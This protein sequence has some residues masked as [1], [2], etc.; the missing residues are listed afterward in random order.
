MANA[1]RKI[2]TQA[3]KIRKRHKSMS[4]KSAVKKA[5]AQYKKG[6]LKAR[7]KSVG[8]VKKTR[9]RR[10]VKRSTARKKT[11]RRK[12]T[13]AVRRVVVIA[14]ARPRRRRSYAKKRSAPRRRVGSTRKDKFLQTLLIGG[15][16]VALG[17]ALFRQNRTQTVYVPTGN[18]VRDSKAQQI[19][20]FAQQ[21]ALS[22][23]Q[24]AALISRIN[25]SS[26]S[27]IDQMSSGIA[28][29]LI[30]VSAYA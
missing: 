7:R 3:K 22:A 20:S 15:A 19:L 28:Q 11:T 12:S 14:S 10:T 8:A 26:D 6:G 4:W 29:G 13:R 25:N 1:L 16:A 27:Q 24:I 17:V 9:K 21:A 23:A 18:S 5:S 2:I 30:P